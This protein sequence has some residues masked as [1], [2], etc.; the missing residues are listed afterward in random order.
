MSDKRLVDKRFKRFSAVI[1]AWKRKDTEFI[2]D[3][4]TD[5]IVWH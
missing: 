3:A 5:D 1:D 2:L 4:M